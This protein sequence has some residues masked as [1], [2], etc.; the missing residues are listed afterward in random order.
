MQE[1]LH[2]A[3]RQLSESPKNLAESSTAG[4]A[5]SGFGA[6]VQPT[7]SGA[8]SARWLVVLFDRSCAG[9][10]AYRDGRTTCPTF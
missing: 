4:Q 1:A 10:H 5:D 9:C 6:L 7:Y 2:C 8:M 3:F